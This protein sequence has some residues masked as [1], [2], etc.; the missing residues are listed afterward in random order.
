MST[1]TK[2][3]FPPDAGEFISLD[4]AD[5]LINAFH[6]KETKKG[7]KEFTKA[8]FFGK[9]KIQELLNCENSVGIRIYY[10]AD[11]DGD[12]IDDKKMVLYAVDKDGKNIPYYPPAPKTAGISFNPDPEPDGG[13]KALDGGLQC[14]QYCP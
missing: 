13:G 9:D 12:G 11:L 8:Y 4:H 2:R 6:E 5:K 14:P 10:G 7:K 1:T 3:V